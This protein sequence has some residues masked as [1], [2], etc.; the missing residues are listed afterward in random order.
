MATK[1][2]DDKPRDK[3]QKDKDKSGTAHPTPNKPQPADKR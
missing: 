2:A 3:S 1:H